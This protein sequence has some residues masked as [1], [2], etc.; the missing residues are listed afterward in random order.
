MNAIRI[1]RTID[2]ETLT[3]PELR[4][5][6]GREV[7]IIVLEESPRFVQLE[8][9]ESFLSLAPKPTPEERESNLAALREMAKTDPT[10]AAWLELIDSDGIDVDA[11]IRNRGFQEET[12]DASR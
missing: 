11:V 9:E 2:S 12:W 8:T 1:R 10:M 7:E 5:L 3:I 6:I 4:G